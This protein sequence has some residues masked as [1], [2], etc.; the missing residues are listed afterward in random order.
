MLLVALGTCVG[1]LGLLRDVTGRRGG[2]R[3]E[4]PGRERPPRRVVGPRA[5]EPWSR[6]PMPPSEIPVPPAGETEK[7]PRKKPKRE[8]DAIPGEYVLS[9]RSRGDRD[10]FVELAEDKGCKVIQLTDF[11]NAVRLRAGTRE[12]FDKL[13]D[14]GPEPSE[15]SSNYFVRYPDL[16]PRDPL[17]PQT[18]Y[19]P[20]GDLAL[21]SLGVT[22]DNGA[23]GQGVT[24]AVL[25]TGIGEHSSLDERAVFQVDLLNPGGEGVGESGHG[26]A[27]ASLI[28]GANEDITGVSPSAKLLSYRVLGDD[29]VGDTFTLAQGIVDAVDRGA[30]VI[31]MCLGTYGDSH[32]LKDAIDYA[33]EAGVVL[34]G[35]AGND[36]VEGV[37]YPAKYEGVIAVAAVDGVQRHLYFSNRGE[38]VDLAAPGMA[39]NAAGPEDGTIL[40]SGTSA[41]VPFVSGT[42]AWLLSENPDMKAEDVT[43]LLRAY[44]DD[45]GAPGTDDKY[46]EG[47]LNIE[48]IANRNVEG[49][50]NA[51]VGSPYL[52]TAA[53]PP[54]LVLFVQNRGTEVLPAIDLKVEMDGIPSVVSFYNVGVGETAT[55]EYALDTGRLAAGNTI[56]V[57]CSA[58][59][60]GVEDAYPTD[61]TRKT[62]LFCPAE[63]GKK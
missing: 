44:A 58:V 50:Y 39:V 11:G 29:G 22:G 36:A 9:F 4:K 8:R 60:D 34:V 41:A 3:E 54:K 17:E 33:I 55:T 23:W 19:T 2:D 51:A 7:Q 37:V 20:F 31:N 63:T 5:G 16:Q 14:E 48:R 49:I 13:L 21:R 61:N 57:T 46:G 12:T 56:E 28:A 42:V 15:W 26:T 62:R 35:A 27:V 52:V 10:A 1:V 25:D 47:V 53:D 40:F 30:D 6:R 45:A 32:I 18:G 38:E 43:A 24:V 59:L